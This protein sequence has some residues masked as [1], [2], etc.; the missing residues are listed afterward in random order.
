MYSRWMKMEVKFSDKGQA[1]PA[2]IVPF[3]DEA[4]G[5]INHTEIRWL[6]NASVL[7]NTRG[8]VIL[9]DPILDGFDMPLLIDMPID[10][11][12]IPKVDELMITHIDGDHL[13]FDTL[14]NIQKVTKSYH[15]P[16]YVADVM[17]EKGYPAI[18]HHVGETFEVS[19]ASIKVTPTKHN[20]QSQVEKYNYRTWKEEEYVGYWFETADGT[21]WLPSDSQLLPE[22]LHMEQPDVILFDFSDNEWHITYEGAVKLANTYPNAQLICIHWG[23]VDAPTWN[24]FNGNPERL[25]ADVVNPER[26]YALNIGEAFQLPVAI[27]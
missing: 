3:G 24:T 27:P 17:R 22:H 16:V 19:G 4:F 10:S 20:W 1:M 26:V 8:N 25:L 9:I 23:S 14:T 5:R 2:A 13:S 21:I 12:Q 11:K 15:A 7:I 18:K 6:G